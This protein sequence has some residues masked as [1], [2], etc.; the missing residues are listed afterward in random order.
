MCQHFLDF[1]L[2]FF[3][4]YFMGF[5]V[6][7]VLGLMLVLSVAG[8]AWYIDRLQDEISVLKGNAIALETQINQQNEAIKQHL[9][10]VQQTQNQV[11][12]LTKKN[13]EAERQVAKLRDTF[14]K[15]DLDNL[16]LAKPKLIETRVNKGTARVKNELVAI[17]NPDQFE[18]NE[19]S[20]ISN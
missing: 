11:N 1:F 7:G 18:E 13:Q 5:K 14:A 3:Y 16:A 12:A 9:A 15:H 2:L 10:K 17:T 19:E 6:A 4:T 8:S 20:N